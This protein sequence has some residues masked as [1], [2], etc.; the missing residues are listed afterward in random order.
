[1]EYTFTA[2]ELYTKNS[3]SYSY[4]SDKGVNES[5][6]L[7]NSLFYRS[8]SPLHGSL[9]M[10]FSTT[11]WLTDDLEAVDAL[12]KRFPALRLFFKYCFGYS[13]AELE[14]QGVSLDFKNQKI[15]FSLGQDVVI[16]DICKV[17][18]SSKNSVV[19]FDRKM[20]RDRQKTL[21][22]IARA[23]NCIQTSNKKNY[24]D[25]SSILHDYKKRFPKVR[26]F[27]VQAPNDPNDKAEKKVRGAKR[28]YHLEYRRPHWSCDLGGS[29]ENIHVDNKNIFTIT[30]PKVR[31][32]VQKAFACPGFYKEYDI[33]NTASDFLLFWITFD[34]AEKYA[35]Q[36]YK[37]NG[38]KEYENP[39]NPA[40]FGKKVGKTTISLTGSSFFPRIYRL[41]TA[42]GSIILSTDVKGYEDMPGTKFSRDVRRNMDRFSLWFANKEKAEEF[43]NLQCV[44]K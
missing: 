23:L 26:V 29:V 31:R 30:T 16:V 18:A 22:L 27:R 3:G 12:E 19:S 2:T 28:Y 43:F 9:A 14:K 4:Y 42:Y 15:K 34:L 44:E 25:L 10:V 20:F 5:L 6:K 11:K 8:A 7:F 37:D 39:K 33:T 36:F 40:V 35:R 17:P 13:I 1:M 32:S 41:K 21:D 24:E 38:M